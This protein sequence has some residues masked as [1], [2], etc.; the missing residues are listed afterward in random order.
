MKKKNGKKENAKRVAE[1]VQ[2]MKTNSPDTSSEDVTLSD[3]SDS[4]ASS[5]NMA[6]KR[7]PETTQSSREATA[8]EF[9]GMISDQKV[10][11]T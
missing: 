1:L 7:V 2:A 5:P 8:Y 11:D 3:S 10:I 4:E 9:A 6:V